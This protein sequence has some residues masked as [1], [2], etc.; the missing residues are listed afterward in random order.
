MPVIRDSLNPTN[1]TT[2]TLYKKREIIIEMY[3][4]KHLHIHDIK[5]RMMQYVAGKV[6]CENEAVVL[7][8]LMMRESDA[9]PTQFFYDDRINVVFASCEFSGAPHDV[10][11]K[12][13]EM[14]I[15]LVLGKTSLRYLKKDFYGDPIFLEHAIELGLTAAEKRKPGFI[16]NGSGAFRIM[17]HF[18]FANDNL[19]YDVHNQEDM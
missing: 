12:K 5:N 2:I 15:D 13:F 8:A 4:Y 19:A 1:P 10:T 16:P 7:I 14:V 17:N 6:S 3:R 11:R 18:P 9:K